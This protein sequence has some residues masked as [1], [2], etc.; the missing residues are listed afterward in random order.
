MRFFVLLS[1]LLYAGP[2]TAQDENIT[3]QLSPAEV[4][5]I[6]RAMDRWPFG[7]RTPPGFFEVQGKI[8]RALDQNPDGREAV[9]E[10][11]RSR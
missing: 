7:T 4:V 11:E 9:K 8:G 10:L 6:T 3:L 5:A 2:A 1:I